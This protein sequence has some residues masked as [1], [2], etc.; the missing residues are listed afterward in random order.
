[1]RPLL[2]QSQ[3][4]PIARPNLQLWTSGWL[5][6]RYPDSTAELVLRGPL[7]Q[8]L[9]GQCWRVY[10]LADTR[11]QTNSQVWIFPLIDVGGVAKMIRFP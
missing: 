9:V 1:M 8:R 11:S 3:S 4:D 10:Q 6:G 7:L 5:V 2:D